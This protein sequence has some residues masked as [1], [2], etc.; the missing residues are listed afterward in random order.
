MEYLKHILEDTFW[1]SRKVALKKS[2][3]S[4][5]ILSLLSSLPLLNAQAASTTKYTYDALGRVRTVQENGAAAESY[6]YDPAGNRCKVVVGV[7]SNTGYCGSTQNINRPPI[8]RIDVVGS[9][10][11]TFTFNPLSNDSDPDGD[12]LTII[13]VSKP[14]SGGRVT[15]VPIPY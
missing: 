2:S 12:T 6:Q 7:H 11:D 9:I 3:F 1:F 8:A 5:V 4:A 14:S 13:A 15:L 10:W